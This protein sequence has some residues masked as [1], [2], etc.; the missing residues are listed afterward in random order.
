MLGSRGQRDPGT[1]RGCAVAFIAG[2]NAG[3][4]ISHYISYLFTL[5]LCLSCLV[6]RFFFRICECCVRKC[7][8]LFVRWE[9]LLVNIIAVRSWF[10][11]I[12]VLLVPGAEVLRNVQC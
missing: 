10:S 1:A 4:L 8:E 3:F 2:N 5:F 12:G 7:C 11:P 9:V 6:D